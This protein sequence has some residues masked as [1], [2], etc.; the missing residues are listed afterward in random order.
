MKRYKFIRMYR[1]SEIFTCSINAPSVD[2]ID[3]Q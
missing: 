2:A 1:G 3:F